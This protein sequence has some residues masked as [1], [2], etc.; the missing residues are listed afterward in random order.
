MNP[1]YEMMTLEEL[2]AYVL[3]HQSDTEA[4]QMLVDRLKAKGERVIYPCP[5]TPE[6]LAIMRQVI[7]EK[8]GQS[9]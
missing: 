9:S 2:R 7:Q 5:N 4:F 3:S 6:N 8:L 1:T